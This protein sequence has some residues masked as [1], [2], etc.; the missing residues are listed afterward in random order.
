MRLA[1]RAASPPAADGAGR[2]RGTHA[3][4][5]PPR[6]APPGRIP[7][8]RRAG[9]AL[10][11][12]EHP[13]LRIR[14]DTGEIREADLTLLLALPAFAALADER[15]FQSCSLDHGIVSWLDGDLDIAPEWLFDHGTSVLAGTTGLS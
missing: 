6:H 8:P 5:H 14:F 3:A 15:S 11:T 9:T 12:L 1:G 10:P 2:V 4:R 7:F 13:R